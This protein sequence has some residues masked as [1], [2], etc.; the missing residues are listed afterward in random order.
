[1]PAYIDP[2]ELPFTADEIRA[3]AS[4]FL[5]EADARLVAETLTELGP[6]MMR[7]RSG[8]RAEWKAASIPNA[9]ALPLHGWVYPEELL[10]AL[11][12]L[13]ADA[14]ARVER[15]RR[16]LARDDRGPAA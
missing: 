8:R 3:A 16:L 10:P 9:D 6:Q 1:M 15:V 5:S 2:E 12:E 13:S 7:E 14:A 11:A 4:R